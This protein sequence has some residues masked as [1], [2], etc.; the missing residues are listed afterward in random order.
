MSRKQRREAYARTL[1]SL[2][3]WQKVDPVTFERSHHRFHFLRGTAY[4]L[5][6]AY[7]SNFVLTRL[8]FESNLMIL[9]I[10]QNYPT[11][12]T[13]A[14]TGFGVLLYAFRE[15]ARYYY[16]LTEAAFACALVHVNVIDLTSLSAQ[17]LAAVAAAL[18]VLVRGLDNLIQGYKSPPIRYVTEPNA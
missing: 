16:G 5:F 14:L 7:L 4:F 2:G 6:F 15:R 8:L 13:M 9:R 18:Y 12:T 11:Q 1:N 17:K 3:K 10:I